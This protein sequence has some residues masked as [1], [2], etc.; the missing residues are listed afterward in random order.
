MMTFFAQLL[1]LIAIFSGIQAK[2]IADAVERIQQNQE[3]SQSAQD[4]TNHADSNYPNSSDRM[5][6]QLTAAKLDQWQNM[7]RLVSRILQ[8]RIY[9]KN[10]VEM[11]LSMEEH[12][13]KFDR[14][15]SML[16]NRSFSL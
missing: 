7:H 10:S 9:T 6:W 1:L 11:Q 3:R 12:H 2:S 16:T 5:Q 4:K 14:N 8:S 13:D 15:R